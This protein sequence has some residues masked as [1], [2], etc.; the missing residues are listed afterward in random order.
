MTI[1]EGRRCALPGC[2]LVIEPERDGRPQRKYCTAA[3]RAVAR[4][5]RREGT[6]RSASAPPLPSDEPASP[7]VRSAQ[8]GPFTS[9]RHRQLAA[10]A[11]RRCRAA[12]VL[13]S[14]GLLVT[15]GG[16]MAASAPAG[17]PSSVSATS[18]NAMDPDSEQ[19]WAQQAQIALVSLESQLKQVE[20][21]RHNW[22][23]LP[24]ER[25]ITPLPVPIRQLDSHRALLLRQSAA[26]R[27]NLTTYQ[28]LR[29]VGTELAN[30]E[31]SLA[32]MDGTLA[33]NRSVPPT[34]EVRVLDQQRRRMLGERDSHRAELAALRNE[35]HASMA[36]PLPAE[37]GSTRAVTSEV[38]TLI[39]HPG[40]DGG[41]RHPERTGAD[42]NP[43][44]V[45][46]PKE[47]DQHEVDSV[48]NG[49]PPDPGTARPELPAS[50]EAL[51]EGTQFGTDHPGADSARA[52]QASETTGA[53]AGDNPGE[54]LPDSEHQD[55]DYSDLRDSIRREYGVES[56]DD[57]DSRASYSDHGYRKSGD[58]N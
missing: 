15:G 16:L 25:K 41:S 10:A 2:Y 48:S 27:G 36:T 21:T 51:A 30:A 44:E 32:A 18:W 12:A 46:A 56:S 57:S 33:Q 24:A 47:L 3:H 14:A 9:R 4:Q 37:W 13:G 38:T 8:L 34:P 1:I 7:Q 42:P 53:V 54:S 43:P 29:K 55:G 49:A 58:D 28:Q 40:L 6:Q 50:P 20:Q 39:D 31:A 11:M 23:A 45:T 26:L 35:L 17:M 5:M 22:E 52:K 19:K